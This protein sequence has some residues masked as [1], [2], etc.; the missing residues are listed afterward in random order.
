MKQILLSGITCLAMVAT[1]F[2]NNNKNVEKRKSDSKEALPIEQ[3]CTREAKQGSEKWTSTRCYT[4]KDQE[5]A[6]GRACEL[7]QA[8]ADAAK[9]RA[10]TLTVKKNNT[11][12]QPTP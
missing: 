4:H 11:I 9:E 8:D 3:C 1:S 10:Y 2:A 12:E 5:I 6:K 7:A